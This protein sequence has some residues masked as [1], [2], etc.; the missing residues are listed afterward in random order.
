MRTLVVAGL[1]LI[2]GFFVGVVLSE[3][4]AI[5]GFLLFDRAV[6]LGFLPIISA[7]VCAGATPIMDAFI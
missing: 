1:A 2:G 4:I 5:I 3:L 6:G 7:P